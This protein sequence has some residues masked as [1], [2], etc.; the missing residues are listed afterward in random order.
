MDKDRISGSAKQVEGS[1]KAVVGRAV[2]DTKLQAD[3]EAD[4]T[5]GKIQSAVGGIKDTLRDALKK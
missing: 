5:E 2:G 3:G 4:K 1:L